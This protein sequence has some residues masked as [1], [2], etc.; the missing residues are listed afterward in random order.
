M[1]VFSCNIANSSIAFRSVNILGGISSITTFGAALRVTMLGLYALRQLTT[2]RTT[3][4]LPHVQKLELDDRCLQSWPCQHTGTLTLSNG[5]RY[6]V[7][8]SAPHV[9][10]LIDALGN[11]LITSFLK[12]HFINCCD[13]NRGWSIAELEDAATIINSCIDP[14][15]EMDSDGYFITHPDYNRK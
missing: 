1:T 15:K 7:H 4:H 9:V 11:R 14:D 10:P 3:P 8:L 6:S 5:K 12:Q 2:S 13:A